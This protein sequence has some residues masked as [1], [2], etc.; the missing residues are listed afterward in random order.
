MWNWVCARKWK[1]NLSRLLLTK[2]VICRKEH[3]EFSSKIW[4][5][6]K[7]LLLL[8]QLSSVRKGTRINVDL[9]KIILFDKSFLFRNNDDGRSFNNLALSLVVRFLTFKFK[10][11]SFS[12]VFSAF[13]II[14]HKRTDAKIQINSNTS[15]KGL[16]DY[17]RKRNADIL[18]GALS[19][20]K[21]VFHQ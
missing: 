4:H 20:T 10:I 15:A 11:Q 7:W 13:N 21:S 5:V 6:Y 1:E 12:R 16:L 3:T 14:D 19:A 18:T 17:K 2:S 9:R 8:Q